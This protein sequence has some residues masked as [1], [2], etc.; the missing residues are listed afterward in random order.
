MYRK[1]EIIIIA[2]IF[3][4]S[5]IFVYSPFC[6]ETNNEIYSPSYVKVKV[7]GEVKKEITLTIPKGY[8][9]G[10]VINKTQIYFNEYSQYDYNLYETIEEDIVLMISTTDINNNY[11]PKSNKVSISYA[12]LD[13]LLTVYGIGEKRALKII[14]YRKKKKIESYEELKQILGVSDE[15]IKKI[16]SQT[17]L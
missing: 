14:E 12:S 8:T 10:Y 4:V 6:K 3:L 11:N 13:E 15:V 2:A 17:V 5:I 9:Y 16:K 1:K 7:E